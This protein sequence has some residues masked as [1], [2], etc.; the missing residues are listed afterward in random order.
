MDIAIGSICEDEH[1][2]NKL[3]NKTVKDNFCCCDCVMIL[4]CP[5]S[6]NFPT[7]AKQL[8]N[9][10]QFIKSANAFLESKKL[11]RVVSR[12]KF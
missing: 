4:R 12:N 11:M 5:P 9:N 2:M 7:N 1:E 6:L 8:I 3:S 10:C